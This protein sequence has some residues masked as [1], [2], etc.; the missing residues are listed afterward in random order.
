MRSLPER[1]E[2]DQQGRESGAGRVA[3]QMEKVK[4]VVRYAGGQVAKG[5]TQDFFPNKTR[6]HLF[7]KEKSGSGESKEIQFH[8]LKAVFFVRDFDGNAEY[9]EQKH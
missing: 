5:F 4:I 6:F 7:P 9:N 2:H 8:E 1:F 3:V